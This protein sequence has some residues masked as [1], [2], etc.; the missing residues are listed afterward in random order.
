MAERGRSPVA[1]RFVLVT[2]KLHVPQPR[3]GLVA[4]SEPLARLAAEADGR[5]TL[6]CAP[7]GWGKSLLLTE[8]HASAAE[9]RPFAWVS[10]DPGD[11]DPVRF[12]SYVI[13]ALRT[14]EPGLGDAP[15]AALPAARPALLEAGPALVGN[16]PGG[17]PR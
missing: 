14:V 2:T 6:V 9:T 12:W 13:G 8:W 17:D 4:R 7:A 16:P 11:D 1:P 15:L 3:P 10:L 5:L